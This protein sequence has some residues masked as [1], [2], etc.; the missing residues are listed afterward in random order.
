MQKGW[1][2]IMFV[3]IVTLAGCGTKQ[4]EQQEENEER[5]GN[6]NPNIIHLDDSQ[7]GSIDLRLE[8]VKEASIQVTIRL[9]GKVE[10]DQ[11]RTAHIR[12]LTSGR[13]TKVHVRPGDRV[14]TGSA[15]VTYDNIELGDLVAE[16]SQALSEADVSARSLERARKLLDLGSISRAE[17]ERR[18]A[19]HRNS[20]TRAESIRIKL[21][22][23]GLSPDEIS[24]DSIA[25]SSRTILRAPFPGILTELD[26]AEGESISPEQK[27]ISISDLSRVWVTGNVFE[28]DLSRVQVGQEA[29]VSTN[30]YPGVVF[31]GKIT[32][33][34]DMV[35]SETQT[36]PV[37]CEI[38]NPD[39]RLKLGLFVTMDAPTAERHTALTVSTSAIQQFG[40]SMAVFVKT[41]DNE[42]EKKIVQIGSKSGGDVE[43]KAG[44]KAGDVVVT[45]GSFQ[46]KSE[47]EKEKIETEEE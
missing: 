9:T 17:F 18:E 37:R 7:Q 19:E 27:I 47:I 26:A 35:N 43:V 23:F 3:T 32:Y 40:D 21:N 8:P 4:L 10:A 34:G 45:Q 15:L 33:I 6:S 31:S 39:G 44:L 20:I 24:K 14:R 2:F 30:A 42:F 12:A 38:D 29:Q 1:L 36:I 22:R 5:Q 25:N 41:G 46:L 11:T 28:K 13:I 16:Y